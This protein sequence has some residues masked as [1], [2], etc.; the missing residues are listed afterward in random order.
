MELKECYLDH[1]V[2]LKSTSN[3]GKP[4]RKPFKSVTSTSN[5]ICLF[6]GEMDTEL[7]KKIA[8]CYTLADDPTLSQVSDKKESVDNH[9]GNNID[10]TEIS[11][12]TNVA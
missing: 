11:A 7:C 8:M 2:R 4:F 6:P 12:I 5:E 3:K 9:V 10:L 1:Y